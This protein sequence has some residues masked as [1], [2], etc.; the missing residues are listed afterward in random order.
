M[1]QRFQFTVSFPLTPAPGSDNFFD[2]DNAEG[3]SG[4]IELWGFEIL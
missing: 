2:D 4:G 1:T 3:D